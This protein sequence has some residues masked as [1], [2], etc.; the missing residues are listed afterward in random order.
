LSKNRYAAKADANQPEIVKQLRR[1]G[2]TV[3]TG[4]DDILVGWK[5]KTYWYEVKISEAAANRKGKTADKQRE[6]RDSWQGHYRIVWR[7]DQIL[8]DMG[9]IG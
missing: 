3:Q 8:V 2:C 9:I 5:G 6:I 7:L 4:H 1:L